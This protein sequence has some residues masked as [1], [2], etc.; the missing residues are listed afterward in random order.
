[1]DQILEFGFVY[2]PYSTE[3]VM[4]Q[5]LTVVFFSHRDDDDVL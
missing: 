5:S 1:M 3:C 2:Q 4:Q